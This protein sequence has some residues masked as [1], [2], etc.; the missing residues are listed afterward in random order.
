MLGIFICRIN[1]NLAP[2]SVPLEAEYGVIPAIP[3]KYGYL[4]LSHCSDAILISWSSKRIGV[5]IER[6]DRKIPFKK[7]CNRFFTSKEK[8]NF[9]ELEEIYQKN[10]PLQRRL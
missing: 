6:T 9:E 1:K 10:P 4:S 5:D 7:I 8:K 3:P 2:L